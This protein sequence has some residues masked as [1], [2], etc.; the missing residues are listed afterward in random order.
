MEEVKEVKEVRSGGLVRPLGGD[1]SSLGIF[2]FAAWVAAVLRS[3]EE[4]GARRGG[5]DRS[6]RNRQDDKVNFISYLMVREPRSAGIKPALH[7][8]VGIWV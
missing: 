8:G 2:D 4:W 3:S 5:R 6:A 1:A 7:G